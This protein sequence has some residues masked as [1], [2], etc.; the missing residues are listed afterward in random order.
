MIQWLHTCK[1]SDLKF[2]WDSTEE[3]GMEVASLKYYRGIREVCLKIRQW[4]I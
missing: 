4:G 2:I 1:K 3:F